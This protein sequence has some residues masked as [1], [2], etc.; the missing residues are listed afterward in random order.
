L[1]PIAQATAGC[2]NQVKSDEVTAKSLLQ[3][4]RELVYA[5]RRAP[6]EELARLQLYG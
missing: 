5:A 2:A 6:S 4:M 3:A 1:S